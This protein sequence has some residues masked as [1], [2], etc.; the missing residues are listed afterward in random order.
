MQDKEIIFAFQRGDKT[1]FDFLLEKYKKRV[2]FFARKLVHDHQEAEDLSQETFLKA[3]RN[4][5][6]FRG[7]SSLLTWLFKICINHNHSYLRKRKLLFDRNKNLERLA[8]KSKSSLDLLASREMGDTI[9][10]KVQKLPKK[11]RLSL[12]LRVWEEMS[13][14]EISIVLGISLDSVK[15]NL[16]YARKTLRKE[17][18]EFFDEL[19]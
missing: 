4:L 13:Y 7:E 16:F 17:C 10:E 3:Y 8:Q 12:I 5:S 1:A 19:S 2:Y 11:Q 15:V 6:K 14:Q 9:R 18:E